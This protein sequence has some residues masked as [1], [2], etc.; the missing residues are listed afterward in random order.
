MKEVADMSVAAMSTLSDSSRTCLEMGRPDFLSRVMDFLKERECFGVVIIVALAPWEAKTLAM[1]IM[2]IRYLGG[3]H[4]Q[5]E[6]RTF[7]L[8][9]NLSPLLQRGWIWMKN[10]LAREKER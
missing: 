5:M 4:L 1:S 6:R 8:E 7:Q 10:W 2:G 9:E 3:L